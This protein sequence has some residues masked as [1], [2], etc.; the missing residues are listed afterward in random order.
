MLPR[1]QILTGAAALIFVWIFL[2]ARG[3]FAQESGPSEYQIKAA[4]LYHFAQFVKW[5]P[6]AFA[7]PTSPVVIGVLGKNMFGGNL[8]QTIRNKTINNHPIEFKQFDSV[9]EAVHCQILFISPSEKGRL[10]RILK[11]LAGASVLTVSET[12]H[13]TDAGGMINFVIENDEVHFQINN[14]AAQKA[15]LKISS[16]LLTLAVH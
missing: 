9:S 16:K 7:S 6:Q 3:V 13:F 15:G 10:P 14:E 5:P 11:G 8:E 1:T 4:F 12:D 2:L